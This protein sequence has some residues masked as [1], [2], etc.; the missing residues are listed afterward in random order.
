MESSFD[1]L[2]DECL[3]HLLL[4]IEDHKDLLRF[5]STCRRIHAISLDIP[6]KFWIKLYA[7]KWHLFADELALYNLETY[8]FSS[9]SLSLSLSLIILITRLHAFI[10]LGKQIIKNEF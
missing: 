4:T 3:F 9:L 5:S 2:A 7:K 10:G 1:S 6:D 8:S